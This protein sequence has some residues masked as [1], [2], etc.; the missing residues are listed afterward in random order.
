MF[1]FPP[2][3]YIDVLTPKGDGISCWEVIRDHE[4]EALMMGL[5]HL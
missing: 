1:V 5:A 2:N 3:S 4:D